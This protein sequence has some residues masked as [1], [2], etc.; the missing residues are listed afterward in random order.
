MREIPLGGRPGQ[1]NPGLKGFRLR[2]EKGRSMKRVWRRK[3]G[4]QKLFRLASEEVGAELVEFAMSALILM[5]FIVIVIGFSMF[6]YTY[7]FVSSAA[8]EG[9]RYA[10]VRGYTWSKTTTTNCSS[11]VIYDCT[12]TAANI[13]TYVQSLATGGINASNVT[14]NETTLWPGETPDGVACSPAYSQGCLVKVTVSYTF[15]FSKFFPLAKIGNL[16]ISATSAG[17]IQQ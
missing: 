8:E 14:I 13:Q 1:W 2:K 9:V 15:N 3:V 11:T 10:A 17:A 6:M 12:A 7:H 16:S 5:A 4:M